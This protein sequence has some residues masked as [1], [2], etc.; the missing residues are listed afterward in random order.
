MQMAILPFIITAFLSAFLLFQVQPLMGKALLPW[1]GGTSLVWTTCMM[2]F[3]ALLL[4]GYG[5]AHLLIVHLKPLAQWTVHLL[6]MLIGILFSSL[7]PDPGY[8][9]T[10]AEPPALHLLTILAVHVGAPFFA[11]SSTAPLVQ[12]WFLGRFP[13]RSP[14]PLYAVSNVGS[15]FGVL[16][17]PFL[18]EPLLPLSTQE[19]LWQAGYVVYFGLF[20]ICGG[21]YW[22]FAKQRALPEDQEE[23]PPLDTDDSDSPRHPYGLWLALSACGSALLLST[24]DQIS[25]DVAASPLFWVVPLCLFLITFILCFADESLYR[26]TLW[27]SLLPVA[28]L[29]VG[30]Q[31]FFG[32]GWPVWV[33]LILYAS[34]L[35]IGCMVCHGELAGLKPAPGQLSRYYFII[36]LGGVSGGIFVALVAPF[37][38]PDLWEYPLGWLALYSL[39]LSV[40]YKEA[41]FAFFKG[42][43]RL[44]WVA[45]GAGWLL[46]AVVFIG[47]VL[48]D[49]R[50]AYV[51]TRTF[52][53][54]VAVFRNRQKRCLY[55]GR[56]RHGCQWNDPQR[57]L[58][59]TTYYGPDTGISVAFGA[60]RDIEQPPSIRF[61]VVGL[62]IGTA[63]V[64]ADRDDVVRFFE[65]DSEV[66]RF[67]NDHFSY[68]AKAPAA[69]ETVIGDGRLSLEAEQN[70]GEKQYD[71]LALDAFAGDAVPLHLL[72]R[73]AFE[74]YFSRLKKD[75]ILVANISNHH[76]RLESLMLGLARALNKEVVLISGQDDWTRMLYG[77]SWII[78]TANRRVIR[79]IRE[80][81]L[82]KAWPEA[83]SEPLL[84][85]D[86]Y[87]NLL[88][89]F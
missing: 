60:Y 64:F 40:R 72:T 74:L 51:T 48:F 5:Y 79:A 36:S 83:H 67:A 81:G 61:G 85:T 15:L 4:A 9:P 19:R 45:F 53:G 20:A 87:S 16:S 14:Y 26:R 30:G 2:F 55:H 63:A 56:I 23:A 6:V 71:I 35:F 62:G 84:F 49:H 76:V 73:E 39:V 32:G 1:F 3:Q 88:S 58:D 86:Q 42:R 57:A 75:G 89:L 7:L 38:F 80:N 69:I 44:F 82:N 21:L 18:F 29:F 43:A 59:A 70:R 66:L 78:M 65:L 41:G 28:I 46:A 68:L 34:T 24:T 25:Q 33:Q 13:K 31:L 52:F 8:Q 10:G 50:E 54:R 77:S 27:L 47:D 17:Y 11:L 12:A 37:I 22:R